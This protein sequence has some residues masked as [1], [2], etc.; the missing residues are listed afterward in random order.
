[1]DDCLDVRYP[2]RISADLVLLQISCYTTKMVG[3]LSDLYFHLNFKLTIEQ[4]NLA[5]PSA[6]LSGRA[7]ASAHFE[8]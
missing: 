2:I 5:T 6:V 1:M 4:M 8:K 7:A 3:N